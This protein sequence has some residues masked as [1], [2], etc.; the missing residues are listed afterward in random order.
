MSLPGRL[1]ATHAAATEVPRRR[2]DA[3]GGA[4][5]GGG[6]SWAGCKTRAARAL[7]TSSL[8]VTNLSLSALIHYHTLYYLP[9][10]RARASPVP[11]ERETGRGTPDQRCRPI[12]CALFDTCDTN[13]GQRAQ[14]PDSYILVS[15]FCCSSCSIAKKI[16]LPPLREPAHGEFSAP[17]A[18]K[19][20]SQRLHPA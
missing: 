5:G 4:R 13:G 20:P 2:N 17:P 18:R 16:Y 12:G 10:S 9:V 1:R 6:E 7:R 19:A 11:C 3:R 15:L 8:L 14:V